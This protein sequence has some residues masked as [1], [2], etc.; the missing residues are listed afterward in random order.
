MICVCVIALNDSS[1]PRR[2][3]NGSAE[4]QKIWAT[5]LEGQDFGGVIYVVDATKREDVTAAIEGFDMLMSAKALKSNTPV[6]VLSNK[7][8]HFLMSP[9]C[10][11]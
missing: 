11:I 6:V 1:S 8:V 10:C 4:G 9:Q 7:Q 2:D 5:H 3:M